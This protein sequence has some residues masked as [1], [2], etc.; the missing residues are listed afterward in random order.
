VLGA[1]YGKDGVWDAQGEFLEIEESFESMPDESLQAQ[2]RS[3]AAWNFTL[4]P[5]V[6]ERG[7]Q[8]RNLKLSDIQAASP[9]S[10]SFTTAITSET[11]K[12]FSGL[13]SF[14]AAGTGEAGAQLQSIWRQGRNGN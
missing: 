5:A 10:G 12:Q 9:G 4:T 11:S 13:S 7:A 2:A 8:Q 3:G 14:T 6:T 1:W